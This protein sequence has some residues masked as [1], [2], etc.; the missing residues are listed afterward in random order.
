MEVSAAGLTDVGRQRQVNEDHFLVDALRGLYVIADGVGGHK[1]GD[2][3]SRLAVTV[4]GDYLSQDVL[5]AIAGLACEVDRRREARGVLVN[6][7]EAANRA[8]LQAATTSEELDGMG[9]TLLVALLSGHSLYAIHA[10]DSRA[11]RF[12]DGKLEALTI[13]HSRVALLVTRG[14]L[15]VEQARLHPMRNLITK[16]AG[17]HEELKPD[18]TVTSLRAGDWLVLCSDGLWEMLTDDR[19]AEIIRLG[20]DPEQVVGALVSTANRAGGR[21]NI[22]AIVIRCLREDEDF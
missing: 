1:G 12:R 15:T 2:T 13:D 3:A 11:Y 14:H 19:I 16:A 10:G 20:K 6:A 22:T 8:I 21:D 5:E 17:L 9:C 18:F 4:V 7:A